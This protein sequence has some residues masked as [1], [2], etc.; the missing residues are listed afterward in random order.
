MNC[1]IYTSHHFTPHGGNE[2]NKLTSL[3]MCMWLH[4]SARVGR[5]SHRYRGGHG[6]ESGC[7]S[8]EFS[9]LKI[10]EFSVMII[11]HFGISPCLSV[12]KTFALWQKK[13][14][15]YSFIS[16]SDISRSFTY[17]T[18]NKHTFHVFWRKQG[19]D[20]TYYSSARKTRYQVTK[21]ARRAK[22]SR[23]FIVLL[24][25]KWTK[26]IDVAMNCAAVDFT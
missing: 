11:L 17:A 22:L 20:V 24:K 15:R 9:G 26:F 6:F 21:W 8:P 19:F 23:L 14:N 16:S 13:Q 12:I 2:P 1:F 18:K 7:W 10:W 3:R 5:A 4:S 25:L